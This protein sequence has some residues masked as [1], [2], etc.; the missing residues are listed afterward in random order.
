MIEAFVNPLLDSEIDLPDQRCRLI[1][2][3][4]E[5]SHILA[6]KDIHL[7]TILLKIL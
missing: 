1:R 4:P 6:V 2:K 7:H 3:Q 5:Q